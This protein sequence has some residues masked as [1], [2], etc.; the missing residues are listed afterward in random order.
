MTKADLIDGIRK[1]IEGVNKDKAKGI[2][3]YIFTEM[4]VKLMQG[5]EVAIHGFGKFKIA[6]RPARTGHNPRT[7]EALEIP[8]SKLIKFKAARETKNELNDK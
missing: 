7:G 3:D 1:N 6:I 5:E 8:E 2:V 4:K